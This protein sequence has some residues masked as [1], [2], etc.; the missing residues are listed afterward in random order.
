MTGTRPA[1]DCLEC[2]HREGCGD[3]DVGIVQCS[4]FGV[5][6]YGVGYCPD[7]HS[8]GVGGCG[9]GYCRRCR[10]VHDEAEEMEDAQGVGEGA[11]S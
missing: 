9:C 8:C 5:E 11:L 2:D 7:C 6:A 10:H 4:R 3:A 1:R